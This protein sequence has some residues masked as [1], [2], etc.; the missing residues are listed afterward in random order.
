MK[1]SAMLFQCNILY[2]TCSSAW[3]VSVTDL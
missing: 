2:I 1:G 3:W